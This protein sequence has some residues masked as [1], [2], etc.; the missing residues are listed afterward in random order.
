MRQGLAGFPELLVTALGN[1]DFMWIC[2]V[3]FCI[4]ILVAFLDAP[5]L[6][7]SGTSGVLASPTSTVNG[8]PTTLRARWLFDL[9]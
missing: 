9:R 4:G 6:G 2:L 3:E 7:D 1:R 8:T 5:R